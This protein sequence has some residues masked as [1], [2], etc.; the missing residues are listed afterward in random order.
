MAP[1]PSGWVIASCVRGQQ[2][3]FTVD[4][5]GVNSGARAGAGGR[6]R[7][8]VRGMMLA[9]RPGG[10]PLLVWAMAYGLSGALIAQMGSRPARPSTSLPSLRPT[11]A[12]STAHGL[13][14]TRSTSSW[15]P[16]TRR[17]SA[18]AAAPRAHRRERHADQPRPAGWANSRTCPGSRAARRTRASPTSPPTSPAE[19]RA[20]MWGRFGLAGE[21]LAE[22]L[23]A[24]S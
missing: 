2:Y 13:W 10:G 23:V 8:W 24:R 21:L 1:I 20:S 22:A 19:T 16:T 9:A 4:A 18:L 3:L 17:A 6:W 7:L 14:L 12:C 5:A 15:P 11:P